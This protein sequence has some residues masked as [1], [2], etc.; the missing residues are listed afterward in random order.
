MRGVTC[1]LFWGSSRPSFVFSLAIAILVFLLF[2]FNLVLILPLGG[3]RIDDT[4]HRSYLS[5]S[6]VIVGIKIEIDFISQMSHV[7]GPI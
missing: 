5:S 1:Q 6:F 3:P 2:G 4:Y 7:R